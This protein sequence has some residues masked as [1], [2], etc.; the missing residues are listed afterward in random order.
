MAGKTLIYTYCMQLKASSAMPQT[1]AV[2]GEL[3][4]YGSELFDLVSGPTLPSYT[5]D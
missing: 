2:F 4:H 3:A 1:Y 5:G